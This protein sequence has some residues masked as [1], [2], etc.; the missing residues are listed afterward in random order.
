MT[1]RDPAAPRTRPQIWA[2]GGGKGG[3]G[4]SVIAVALGV[5]LAGRGRDVAL[6]DAAE[7]MLGVEPTPRC[8]AIRVVLAELSRIADHIVCCGLAG[9]V[10][11][12]R[13]AP[14]VK[15]AGMDRM[16]TLCDTIENSG[17][18]ACPTEPAGFKN[19]YLGGPAVVA[20]LGRA[21]RDLKTQALFCDLFFDK[22]QQSRLTVLGGRLSA[23]IDAEAGRLETVMGRAGIETITVMSGR[24]E[25]LK[26]IAWCIRVEVLENLNKVAALLDGLTG[27]PPAHAIRLV[28]KNQCRAQQYRPA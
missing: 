11:V 2:I 1:S 12:G 17:Y 19:A 22:E 27:R 14:P 16:E 6:V 28:K 3:V 4:K 5:T 10:S 24:L 23:L 9:I 26:D 20:D 7:R 25:D 13:A 15:A 18:A 21:A 8:V